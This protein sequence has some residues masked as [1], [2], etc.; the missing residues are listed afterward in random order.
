M[1]VKSILTPEEVKSGNLTV[2]EL[3]RDNDDSTNGLYMHM[4]SFDVQNAF[5]YLCEVVL[6]ILIIIMVF[7]TATV[8][9]L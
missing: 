1:E 9:T 2:T 4:I 5:C 7:V 8:F 6:F 3:Q